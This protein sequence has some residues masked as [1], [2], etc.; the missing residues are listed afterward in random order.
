MTTLVHL[1]IDHRNH[2]ERVALKFI[3]NRS[4]YERERNVS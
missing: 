1:A 4:H 3:K 2:G